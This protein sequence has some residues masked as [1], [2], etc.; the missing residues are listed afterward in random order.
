MVSNDNRNTAKK[1]ANGD[2]QNVPKVDYNFIMQQQ[3]VYN[4]K[5]N[6]DDEGN[7]GTNDTPWDDEDDNVAPLQTANALDTVKPLTVTD[8][9]NNDMNRNSDSGSQEMSYSG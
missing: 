5:N 4:N 8:A 3:N 9:I 7:E 6:E 1:T 2:T